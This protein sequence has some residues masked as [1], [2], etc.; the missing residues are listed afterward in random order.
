MRMV[1]PLRLA[2]TAAAVVGGIAVAV[3]ADDVAAFSGWIW[4]RIRGGYT[5]DERVAMLEPAV[6]ARLRPALVAAGLPYPPHYLAFLAFKDTRRLE[7][8]AKDHADDPWRL[9]RTYPIRGM[10]GQAGPKL[11]EG[12]QQVPEGI[13]RIEFLNPNSRFHVSLRLNYPNPFDRAMARAEGRDS[14]GSDIMIHGASASVG[15]L[16]MGNDAA[17]DL[18][19]LSARAGIDNTRVIVSP[20]DFRANA[21]PA[22]DDQ[23]PW[24]R[25]LYREI[26]AAIAGF[27]T[28][29]PSRRS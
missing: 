4:S 20:T 28:G 24:V 18:F 5:L 27:P 10:S 9:V 23:L 21:V 13:Y 25:N 12:D 1:R 26:D 17:E 16:A 22:A 2:L 7:L 19:V 15:C 8:Y 14:P 11:R 29:A 3:F 6:D